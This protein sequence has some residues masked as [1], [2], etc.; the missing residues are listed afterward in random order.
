MKR[1]EQSVRIAETG[2]QP[3]SKNTT[4]GAPAGDAPFRRGL[5]WERVP[6]ATVN[7]KNDNS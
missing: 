6:E 7:A 2:G 1:A 3:S 5:P 4:A